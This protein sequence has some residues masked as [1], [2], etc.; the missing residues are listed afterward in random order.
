MQRQPE[1]PR[2]LADFGVL[3]CEFMSRVIKLLMNLGALSKCT[4]KQLDPGKLYYFRVRAKGAAGFGPWS[5]S[6]A[7]RAS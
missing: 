1:N 3:A 2:T 7:K 5:D 4:L 6:A